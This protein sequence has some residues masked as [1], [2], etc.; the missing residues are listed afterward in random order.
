MIITN[1]I[2]TFFTGSLEFPGGA[3]V[4]VGPP[5][6][7]GERVAAVVETAVVVV[8]DIVVVDVIAG[9][10]GGVEPSIEPQPVCFAHGR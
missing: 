4:I 8:A 3:V 10:V 2:I 1:T 7:F 9:I 6:P 5:R